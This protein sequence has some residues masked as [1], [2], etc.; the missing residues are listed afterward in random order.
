MTRGLSGGVASQAQ[1]DELWR[2]LSAESR[3]FA[4]AAPPKDDPAAKL[5][6]RHSSKGNPKGASPKGDP[7]G[8]NPKGGDPKGTTKGQPKAKAKAKADAGKNGYQQNLK[9]CTFFSTPGGCSK[10]KQCTWHHPKLS[11][12]DG[13]C[14][15]CGSSRHRGAECTRPRGADAPATDA[16]LAAASTAPAASMS[17]APPTSASS[18]SA[19]IAAATL[20]A[21]DIRAE[22]R[23][24]LFD[25]MQ[26]GEQ[27]RPA[28]DVARGPH[29]DGADRPPSDLDFWNSGGPAAKA[30][31]ISQM[32]AAK[33][34]VLKGKKYLL[35][36]TGA[37]H[38]LRGIASFDLLPA[39]ARAVNLDT[40]TGN[41][42]ARMVGDIVYVLGEHLQGLFPLGAYI[43]EL[44]LHLEWNADHCTL[45]LPGG[46]EMQLVKA[47]TSIYIA[48]DDAAE[49]RKAKKCKL[50]QKFQS[51]VATMAAKLRQ[52]AELEEHKRGGHIS[53]NAS[54]PQCRGAA[55]RMRPH[56]R[57]DMSTRP[58]GQL[59]IDMSG[60][61]LPGRWPS[62]RPEDVPRHAV[63]F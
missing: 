33:A 51:N 43:E 18:A 13:R 16:L 25:L 27:P 47:G 4:D 29:R 20:T 34:Y 45:A 22:I 21:D 53:F 12:S 57:H 41:Q 62:G 42:E 58:G 36:D 23:N 32:V 6:L 59:S 63:H 15:N 37:T 2:Y 48:E 26:M 7:K 28:S 30:V 60:P 55:G 3:E 56:F 24:E 50:R 1:V 39:C 10:G 19:K 17:E 14:F 46:R 61:H 52:L 35:A 40:A 9:V 49:L 5:A 11:P 38:E 31:R 44:G 8:R 54:C